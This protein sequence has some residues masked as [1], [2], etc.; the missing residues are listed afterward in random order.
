MDRLNFT[1][2]GRAVIEGKSPTG[3]SLF[4]SV[5]SVRKRIIYYSTRDLLQEI[6]ANV[7]RSSFPPPKLAPHREITFIEFEA[8]TAKRRFFVTPLVMIQ[9]AMGEHCEFVA[10]AELVRSIVG[11]CNLP[12]ITDGRPSPALE[13]V[14]HEAGFLFLDL[15]WLRSF[16]FRRIPII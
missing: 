4:A 1:G 11:R 16:T 14:L 9:C 8:A 5:V 6:M 12:A 3:Q 7:G 15:Y 13:T 10:F 2:A